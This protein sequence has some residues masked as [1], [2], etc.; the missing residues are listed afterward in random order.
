MQPTPAQ[1]SSLDLSDTRAEQRADESRRAQA[2]EQGR[3]PVR[4]DARVA[5]GSRKILTVAEPTV[6]L[7]RLQSGIGTLRFEA[8]CSAEVGDLRLGAVYQLASGPSSTVQLSGGNRY[9][10][11]RSRRPVLVGAHERFEQVLVDLRQSRELQRLIVY[12]FSESRATL[13]WGGTLVVDTFGEAKVELPLES[14]QGGD[15]AVLMSLYNIRG[16]FVLRAEM[17]ALNGGVREAAR[18]YGFD[19]ITWLDDRT[20]V[21]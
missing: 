16:E 5:A 14:L 21:E 17:Q 7:T 12:A 15:V 11:P 4:A 2:A 10:P 1:S 18:G 9:A 13:R 19:K 6:T 3:G 20:P 8:A